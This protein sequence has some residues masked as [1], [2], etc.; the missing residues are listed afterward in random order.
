MQF[1][2]EQFE[3]LSVSRYLDRLNDLLQSEPVRIVGEVAQVQHAASG[4]VYFVLK[5]KEGTA[6][7]NCALWRSRAVMYGGVLKDGVEVVLTG[8]A[9]IYAPNGRLSFIAEAVELVGE[10]ALKAQYEALKKK[11]T[12]EGLFADERKK[13]L[14]Q[15]PRVIGVITSTAGAVIHDFCNNLGRHGFSVRIMDARVEGAAAVPDLLAAVKTFK[16]QPLEA[17][18]IIRGGGSFESLAAFD[19]EALV[20]A[21][22]DLP[23]PVIAGIG[24]HQDQ[25]LLCYAADLAVSTPTAAAVALTQS[26]QQAQQNLDQSMRTIFDQQEAALARARFTLQHATQ[27]T[28]MTVQ[29]VITKQRSRVRELTR[30]IVTGLEYAIAAAKQTITITEQ[31]IK[32]ND[33]ARHLRLGYSLVRHNGTIVTSIKTM[34][35]GDPLTVTVADGTL[36]ITINSI[37]NL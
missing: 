8:A 36:D 22:C 13:V 11:L 10:G 12:N 35:P 37:H 3:P 24:H 28:D 31:V 15:Y 19:N 26:W 21:I 33:P 1:G 27:S 14:P 7:I 5:D 17:L 2:A 34:Q 30:A 25:P 4:H 32:A 16:K 9:N 6:L 18:V 20:R 23:F 29:S